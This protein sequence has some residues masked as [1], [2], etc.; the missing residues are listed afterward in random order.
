MSSRRTHART[1]TRT[2]R[3]LLVTLRAPARPTTDPPSAL[4]P[5]LSI[6][7]F[8]ARRAPSRRLLG[9]G[10]DASYEEVKEARLY[11]REEYVV[12]STLFHSLSPIF[13]LRSEKT[14]RLSVDATK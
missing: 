3:F 5:F 11:L 10:A 8:F 1:H 9:I 14:R 4:L 2:P 12:F 13:S 6:L 7:S